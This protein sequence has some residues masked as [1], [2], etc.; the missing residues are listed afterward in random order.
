MACS[1]F[2]IFDGWLMPS[3]KDFFL[4]SMV[5]ILGGAANLLNTKKIYKLSEDI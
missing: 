5:G 2:T 4:L 1:I 3:L